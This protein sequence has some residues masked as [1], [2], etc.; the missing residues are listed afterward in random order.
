M[1]GEDQLAKR[2]EQLT[3]NYAV[4]S[5]CKLLNQMNSI[6]KIVFEGEHFNNRLYGIDWTPNS[7]YGANH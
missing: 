6:I 2:V 1:D 3:G 4:G 5:H 7:G